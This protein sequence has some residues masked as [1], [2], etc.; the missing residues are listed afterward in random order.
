MNGGTVDFLEALREAST[1]SGVP[2]THIGPAM[3]KRPNYASVYLNKR[4]D[5]STT[6]AAAMLAPCGYALA[7]VPFDDLPASALVIDSAPGD[8]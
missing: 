3:G 8:L 6:T 4:R 5:P 7:A 1:E 2:L